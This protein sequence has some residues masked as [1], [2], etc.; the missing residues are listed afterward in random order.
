MKKSI[1]LFGLLLLSLFLTACW[2]SS[3]PG[4]EHPWDEDEVI[5]SDTGGVLN[6]QDGGTTPTDD[7]IF[8][9]FVPS[10]P[11]FAKIA[12]FGIVVIGNSRL[13]YGKE[14]ASN[15]SLNKANKPRV[16]LPSGRRF[17]VNK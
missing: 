9:V 1:R 5:F 17:K 11:S 2:L 3:V 7:R 15:S 16:Y 4:S 12:G 8:I 6:G 13:D 14:R 10:V